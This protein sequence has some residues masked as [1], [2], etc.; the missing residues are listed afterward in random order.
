MPAHQPIELH[1][2]FIDAFNRGDVDS[3]LALFEPNATIVVGGQP[4]TGGH[5]KLRAALEQWLAAS[6]HMS[7]DTRAVIEGPEGLVVLHGAWAIASS[8][9]TSATVRRGLSTEVARRQSDGTW[10]IVID[11]PNMPT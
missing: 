9:R 5:D 4:V 3:L 6:G 10:R 11:N 1:G 2:L 8:E 7:L